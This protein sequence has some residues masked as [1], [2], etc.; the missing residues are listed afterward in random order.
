MS[1]KFYSCRDISKAACHNDDLT[2]L[3]RMNFRVHLFMCKKC[4]DYVKDIELIG[5]KFTEVINKKRD[6]SK[7]EIT[8]LENRVLKSLRK[9]SENE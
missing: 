5:K 3:E 1:L 8:E 2:T 4:R 7:K 9:K 6:V